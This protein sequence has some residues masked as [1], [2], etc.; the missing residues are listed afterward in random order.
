MEFYTAPTGAKREKNIIVYAH[1][2]VI[3]VGYT[4]TARKAKQ[5]DAPNQEDAE[6]TLA[7]PAGLGNKKRRFTP[8]FFPAIRGAY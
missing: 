1:K 4:Q 7:R 5:T 8:S 3:R 6:T 2:P